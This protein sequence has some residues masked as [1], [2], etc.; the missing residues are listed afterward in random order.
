MLDFL[1]FYYTV[2]AAEEW[3]ECVLRNQLVAVVFVQLP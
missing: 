3:S 1:P 2:L